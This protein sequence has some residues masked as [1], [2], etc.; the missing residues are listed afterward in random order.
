VFG[1]CFIFCNTGLTARLNKSKRVRAYITTFA[2]NLLNKYCNI[3]KEKNPWA[4][5]NQFGCYTF[6]K[7]KVLQ[8][9]QFWE[10]RIGLSWGV[11]A[12]AVK[13]Q[14]E[15]LNRDQHAIAIS[16]GVCDGTTLGSGRE[17]RIR[18]GA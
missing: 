14:V 18:R 11:S 8:E 15:I 7:T 17:R 2:P 12:G 5:W 4:S 10:A 1:L 6:A 9:P 13:T 3:D 16:A